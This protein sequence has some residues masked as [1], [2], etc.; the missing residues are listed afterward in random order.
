MTRWR[1]IALDMDG[2]LLGKDGTVSPENKKWIRR[3]REAG[4]EV[5]IATGRPCRM[6]RSYLECLD[7]QVPFVAANGSEVWTMDGS[8]LERHTLCHQ[9]IAFLHQLARKYGTHFWSSVV[10]EVFKPD[11][12]PE[13]VERYH[14]LKFG[15]K[16]EDP[17]IIEQLW[18]R[19]KSYGKLECTSSDP[20]NI[21][22]NPEGV[23]KATGLQ[24]VCDYLGILPEQVAAMGD[25]LND[26]AM[27]RWAGMGFAMGNAPLEVRSSADRVTPP[28]WEDGVA[29]AIQWLLR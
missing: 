19:L 4:I 10:G 8:L 1:L 21:E 9:D 26:V 14:W 23:S 6:I 12:F 5:T 13:D 7:L 16:S 15:F 11:T 28:H 20:T 25:G 3:A 22:V 27:L 18:K 29:Q 17:E 24:R 2:T